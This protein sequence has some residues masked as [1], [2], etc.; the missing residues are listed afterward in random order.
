MAF[1]YRRKFKHYCGKCIH[2]VICSRVHVKNAK[3]ETE[4][5]LWEEDFYIDKEDVKID[6]N[7]ITNS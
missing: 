4:Y 7:K 1:E 6:S 5:C 2:F 3:E